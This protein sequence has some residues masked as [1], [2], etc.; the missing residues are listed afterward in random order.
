MGANS[1]EIPDIDSILQKLHTGKITPEDAIIEAEKIE[2]SK[3]DYH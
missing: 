2:R 3:A 1:S